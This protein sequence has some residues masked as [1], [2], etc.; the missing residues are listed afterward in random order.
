M[1]GR[2]EKSFEETEKDQLEQWAF[3]PESKSK[4]QTVLIRGE[5]SNSAMSP[6][7]FNRIS[8]KQSINFTNKKVTTDI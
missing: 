4:L 7:K 6:K 3:L 2:G 8:K 1:E 5:W